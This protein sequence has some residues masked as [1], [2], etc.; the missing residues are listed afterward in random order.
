MGDDLS[1]KGL[2]LGPVSADLR[3]RF[4]L[5]GGAQGLVVTAIDPGS[6]AASKLSPGDIVFT[7]NQQ[8]VTTVAGLRTRM[9]E[10]ER[11]GRKTVLLLVLT[12][13]GQKRFVALK[14]Q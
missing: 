2:H 11:S 8:A 4:G 10:I 7:A 5:T 9:D 12:A 13:D 14:L 6:A 3:E 1:I